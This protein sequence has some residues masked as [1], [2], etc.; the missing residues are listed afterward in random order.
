M[1]C[2][3]GVCGSC[4]DASKALLVQ[5]PSRCSA[6][7]Q[8]ERAKVKRDRGECTDCP[9]PATLGHRECAKHRRKRRRRGRAR[10]RRHNQAGM[11]YHCAEPVHPGLA[12]CHRHAVL[13]RWT[14]RAKSVGLRRS[15]GKRWFF[16]Q[17][18]R[19]RGQ[20]FY[21]QTPLKELG[22]FY[23]GEKPEHRAPDNCE[24]DHVVPRCEGGAQS[25]DNAVLACAFCNMA[26]ADAPLEVFLDACRRRG[27]R[28]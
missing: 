3:N 21:C 27:M 7:Y 5:E 11:C 6:C 10:S 13:D 1:A 26:K 20:C 16:S 2:S 8:R 28:V 25:P 23:S 19:Q 9:N 22:F 12:S 17:V 18:A 4:D 24:I 15:E 14:H